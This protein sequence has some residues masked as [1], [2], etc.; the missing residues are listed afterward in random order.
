MTI[1]QILAGVVVAAAGT[2]ILLLTILIGHVLRLRPIRVLRLGAAA[3]GVAIVGAT[4]AY[5][6]G[7]DPDF[8]VGIL[9]SLPR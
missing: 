9:A 7:A 2:T 5:V 1:A 4:A 3:V 8:A 6:L